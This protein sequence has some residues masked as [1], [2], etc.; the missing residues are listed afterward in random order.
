MGRRTKSESAP[1]AAAQPAVRAAP[2]V[3]L[4]GAGVGD[5]EVELGSVIG[6]FGFRGEVR[7]HLHNPGSTLLARPLPVVLVGPDGRRWA[8][9]MS[10][11]RGAGQRVIGRI[12][13]ITDE[14]AASA[15]RG[16]VVALA[17]A[18][19]PALGDDEFYVWQLE[20]AA[21]HLDGAVVGT[22][23]RVQEAGPHEVLEIALTDGDV[24]FVP[25][26]K[27][28]VASIDVQ[29]RVVHLE[30]GALDDDG[31]DDGDDGP[32]DADDDGPDAG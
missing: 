17:K 29:A 26:L 2:G 14:H 31:G 9:S 19:L 20:G 18:H 6:V 27:A 11:R 12:D 4:P 23:S 24:A 7:V 21:V 3:P 32:D 1:G 16:F 30:P 10:T 8:V 22:V 25:V 13:G 15:L 28:F 5:D